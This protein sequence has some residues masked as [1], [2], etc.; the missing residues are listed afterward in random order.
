MLDFE[1]L[2]YSDYDT[3]TIQLNEYLLDPLITRYNSDYA[4]EAFYHL[5]DEED[6]E[7]KPEKIRGRIGLLIEYALIS[8]LHEMVEEDT[9]R[10]CAVTFNTANMFADFFIRSNAKPVLRV[11]IKA[12]HKESDEASA[13]FDTRAADIDKNRDYLLIARWEWDDTVLRATMWFGYGGPGFDPDV[14]PPEPW[15]GGSWSDDKYYVVTHLNESCYYLWD[16]G[17]QA[18][19]GVSQSFKQW[20]ERW[21]YG[22]SSGHAPDCM[23][24]KMSTRA[25]EIPD[26]FRVYA[27]NQDQA[28][29]QPVIFAAGEPTGKASLTKSASQPLWL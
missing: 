23:E 16:G 21:I 3:I 18:Q 1:R 20:A 25:G 11:D 29:T 15:D 17:V 6:A 26:W 24:Q 2:D 4:T 7:D 10:R 13:R 12:F 5:P 8:I 14:F 19:W 27:I 28:S 9:N 22:P